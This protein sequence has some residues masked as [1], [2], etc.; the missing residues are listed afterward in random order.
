VDLASELPQSQFYD[1][2]DL[3]L[4]NIIKS[5]MN[6]DMDREMSRQMTHL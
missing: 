3:E 6:K 5:S 4:A 2:F 1:N